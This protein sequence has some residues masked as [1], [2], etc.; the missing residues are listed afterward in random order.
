M[1]R[2][3]VPC[4]SIAMGHG[5]TSLFSLSLSIST[6]EEY[7]P[8]HHA[9]ATVDDCNDIQIIIVDHRNPSPGGLAPSHRDRVHA[10]S[11]DV[12]IIVAKLSDG[13]SPSPICDI[14]IVNINI[15]IVLLFC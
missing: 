10:A 15:I 6:L 12:H 5:H 13:D 1:T 7:L 2:L 9:Y 3:E 11:V 14:V 4:I 8:S